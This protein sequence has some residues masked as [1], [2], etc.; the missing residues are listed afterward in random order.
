MIRALLA[1]LLV[2]APGAAFAHATPVFQEPASGARLETAPEVVS[3]RFSERLEEGSS[4]MRIERNGSV[5]SSERA[6]VVEADPHTLSL[7]LSGLS[8]GTYSVFW[9]VISKD[10]GHFTKGAYA[11]SIGSSSAPL[12]QEDTTV[13]QLSS[14][15]EA[16]AL[17]AEFVGNSLA[18]GFLVVLLFARSA[19]KARSSDGVLIRKL[20]LWGFCAAVLF[21][22]GGG[23][24]HILWKA[25]ELSQLHVESIRESLVLYLATDAGEAALAR[26][27]AFLVFGILVLIL[28]RQFSSSRRANTYDVLLALP[29][30][31]FAYFRATVSHATAN[32]FF[33]EFSV[34]VNF[35]HLIEKDVWFGVLIALCAYGMTRLGSTLMPA[36]LAPIYSFLALNVIGIAITASYIIW[37]HLKSVE[38]LTS[39][40]WGE[41]AV[42]LFASAG[43]L[44]G[45]RTLNTLSLR[46]VPGS[47]LR[48][49]PLS[50]GAE[51]VAAACVVFFSALI[52]IT[53]PPLTGEHPQKKVARD[54]GVELVLEPSAFEKS[55]ALLTLSSSTGT[56]VV[57]VGEDELL[58]EL[59]KRFEGG[60][61]FPLDVLATSTFVRITALQPEGYDAT[62]RIVIEEGMLGESEGRTF[63]TFTGVM[64]IVALLGSAFALIL[65]L[66]LRFAEPPTTTRM[67]RMLYV[68]GLALGVVCVSFAVTAAQMHLPNEFK[69][70]CL[71]A[72]NA[73]HLMMP[74]KEGVAVH[75]TPQEG[76]MSLNSTYHI[77]D[78]REYQ[79]LQNLG[80]A[81]VLLTP[82]VVQPNRE[83][84]M[85]ISLKEENGAPALLGLEHE[86]IL[87]MIIISADMSSFAHIHPED[88][89]E[90]EN[91]EFR[92]PYT[93]P[94]A[95]SYI[96]ALDYLH[97]LTHESQ[98]FVVVAGED[99]KSDVVRYPQ[100]ARAD[101]VSVR[102]EYVP[103]LVGDIS[104]LRFEV[105]ENGMPVEDLEP[106]LGAAMHLAIVRDDLQSFIHT[107]GEVH[108]PGYV[109]PT[110]LSHNHAP[111][112][113]RFGPTVEAH[114]QLEPG[115]YTIFGELQRKGEVLPVRF[116]V[117]VD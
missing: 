111:P 7:P 16:F 33:P 104:L 69:R 21:A 50:L 53:S 72:G 117:R 54:K 108:P 113:A 82:L 112:P 64:L 39:T 56:P 88:Y 43:V 92:I 32:P 71:S 77:S 23:V 85:R 68:M 91:G 37:L 48:F 109:A 30:L 17:F 97:G 96:V 28:H 81:K 65:H 42:L 3:I 105:T 14:S 44:L 52:I 87:H 1:V 57:Q 78:Y 115:V 46:Y 15:V 114:V 29:L 76:C 26:I 84:M 62:Y 90:P 93:F 18:W 116:T 19:L 41:T 94:K 47:Y 34:F 36:I 79:Y 40:Q 89:A 25:H 5:V 86:K 6:I 83:T 24:A 20:T 95:G 58:L 59:E 60:Y 51:M 73:W 38:N 8:D 106:Y 10:D 110:T 12:I 22:V 9:S 13:V 63:D 2:F 75:D 103:P 35:V 70:L 67:P 27:G 80:T 66:Q 4:R 61:V 11:F 107:H 98:T 74:T 101:Q 45:F 49:M 100:T 99:E 31:V 102:F 55:M